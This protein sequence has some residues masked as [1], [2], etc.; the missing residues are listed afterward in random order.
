MTKKQLIEEA[1]SKGLGVSYSGT[2]NTVFVKGDG[3]ETFVKRWSPDKT[4][5]VRNNKGHFIKGGL[6]YKVAVG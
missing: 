5:N 6:R 2:T 1:R 3:S 4:G